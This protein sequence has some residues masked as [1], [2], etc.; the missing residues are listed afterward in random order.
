[1]EP[2]SDRLLIKPIEEEQVGAG[3]QQQA[4]QQHQQHKSSG[5]EQHHTS[6]GHASIPVRLCSN[7]STNTGAMSVWTSVS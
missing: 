2:L 6:A 4:Q 7:G 1:M 5:V 3:R